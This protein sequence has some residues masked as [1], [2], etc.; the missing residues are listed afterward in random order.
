M[1][2]G[3]AGTSAATASSALTGSRET[4]A[5]NFDAFLSLL[6]TQLK[7]QNPLEPLD[8]NQFTEQ[9]I[10]FTSVE[11]QLKT[12]EYLEALVLAGERA[13]GNSNDASTQAVNL[14]GKTV[15]A[16][17]SAAELKDGKASWTYTV[18]RNAP[19]SDITIRNE[20]GTVVFTQN[21]SLNQGQGTF[22]WDGEDAGG[23]PFPDGQYSI[24]ID[25]RDADENPIT[26][27][28]QVKGIVESVD[29]T[30]DEPILTVNGSRLTLGAILSVT[31]PDTGDT[32]ETDDTGDDTGGDDAV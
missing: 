26:V 3:I 31:L 22:E 28:T 11:Q 7:H 12:N 24:T 20:A 29:L 4:I 1:V 13:E 6:T 5:E 25:A 32:G 16:G 27:L 21:L 10:K 2:D 9:L 8:T 23:L 14:I 30:G 15:V 17:S 19:S 18:A